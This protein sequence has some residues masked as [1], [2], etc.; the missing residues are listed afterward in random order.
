VTRYLLGG[1]LEGV[2]LAG[3]FVGI[4]VA[5]YILGGLT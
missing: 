1:V 5:L 4:P 3:L 2:V